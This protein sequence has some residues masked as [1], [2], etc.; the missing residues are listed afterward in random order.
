MLFANPDL[1]CSTFTHMTCGT[2]YRI[3]L[4]DSRGWDTSHGHYFRFLFYLIDRRAHQ[5]LGLG[6]IF[7]HIPYCLCLRDSSLG[8]SFQTCFTGTTEAFMPGFVYWNQYKPAFSDFSADIPAWYAGSLKALIL[9]RG[10]HACSQMSFISPV[11]D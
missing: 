11:S 2:H 6:A 7:D 10:E 9:R 1:F 5:Y 3:H 4:N 8:F